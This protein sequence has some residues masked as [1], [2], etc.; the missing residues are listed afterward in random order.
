MYEEIKPSYKTLWHGYIGGVM[1]CVRK[2]SKDCSMITYH[3][4]FLCCGRGKSFHLKKD[5]RTLSTESQISWGSQHVRFQTSLGMWIAGRR[6]RKDRIVLCEIATISLS[7]SWFFV[8]VFFSPCHDIFVV[9]KSPLSI[10]PRWIIWIF[11]GLLSFMYVQP[12][13]QATACSSNLALVQN[14]TTEMGTFC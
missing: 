9:A 4:A 2:I 1:S 10:L 13:A 5:L 12:G 14:I 8:G 3:F 11:N 7:M 6:S